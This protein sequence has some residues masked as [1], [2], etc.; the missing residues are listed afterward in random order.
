MDTDIYILAGKY[1][2]K[3]LHSRLIEI[4]RQEYTFL[5][6]HFE[7]VSQVPQVPQVPQITQV[8]Q[9]PLTL[10]KKKV[11][12]KSKVKKVTLPVEV[13]QNDVVLLSTPETVEVKDVIVNLPEKAGFRDP[14]EVREF[15]KAGEEAKRKENDAAGVQV[16]QILTKE[17]LKKWIEDEGRTYAW[18]AREKAG[19][20]DTQVAATAQMMGIKSKISKKRGMILSNR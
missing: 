19:C 15:Q 9:A 1:G 3:A 2:F 10:E 20:A 18:V 12:R 8:T 16:F 14:K 13:P 5:H 4:M 11:V 17:N 7:Q 6:S